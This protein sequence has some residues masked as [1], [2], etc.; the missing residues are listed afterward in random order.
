MVK[1]E[2]ANTQT[3][4]AKRKRDEIKQ[5]GSTKRHSSD[6]CKNES[7]ND[8]SHVPVLPPSNKNVVA[9]NHHQL[10]S[11]N[12]DIVHDMSLLLDEQVAWF[13]SN[14]VCVSLSYILMT[15]TQT[16]D[17]KQTI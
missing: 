5:N 1:N 12:A 8:D 13:T 11:Y 15:N 2:K 14:A 16:L 9:G 10:H 7:L 17:A 3:A 4:K 6:K